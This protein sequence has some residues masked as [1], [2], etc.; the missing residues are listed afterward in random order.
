MSEKDAST[1]AVERLL[2]LTASLLDVS[3]AQFTPIDSARDELDEHSPIGWI[4]STAKPLLI[5]D[6]SAK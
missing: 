4:A 3:H 1:P 5:P 6:T 2:T